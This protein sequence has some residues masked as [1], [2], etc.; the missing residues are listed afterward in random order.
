MEW[1]LKLTGAGLRLKCRATEAVE[2]E[3]EW[4][5]Q[6]S[7]IHPSVRPIAAAEIADVWKEYRSHTSQNVMGLFPSL[8]AAG[9][10]QLEEF[11]PLFCADAEH[12]YLLDQLKQIGFI[13][14]ASARPT[15]R[16]RSSNR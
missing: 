11:R 8:V 3:S 9:A 10:R 13:P 12:P 16:F 5:T 15:G 1:N 2:E 14:I 4:Y 6:S 7:R